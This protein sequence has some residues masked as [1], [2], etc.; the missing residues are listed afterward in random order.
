MKTNE[1]MS[2]KWIGDVL[3]EQTDTI[4]EMRRLRDE[5]DRWTVQVAMAIG[6]PPIQDEKQPVSI[7]YTDLRRRV[8]LKLRGGVP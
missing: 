1:P 7:Q 2:D 5:T 4:S 6:V 8:L 3:R